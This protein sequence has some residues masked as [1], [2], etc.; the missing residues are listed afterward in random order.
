MAA[1]AV[2]VF[3]RV[4]EPSPRSP[5][6][7]YAAFVPAG[8]NAKKRE[9]NDGSWQRA[10]ARGWTTRILASNHNAQRSHPDLLVRLLED[11]L[12]DRNQP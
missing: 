3:S 6:A 7:T 5:Q 8:E 12:R 1:T 11:A 4:A 10:K 2:V 9:E